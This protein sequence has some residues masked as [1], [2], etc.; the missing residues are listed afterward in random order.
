MRH[1]VLTRSAYGPAWDLAANRRRLEISRAVTARLLACQT[2]RN[3]TWIVLLDERDPLLSERLALY[4][5]SAPALVPILRQSGEDDP[6]RRAAADYRA[7]WRAATGPADDMVLMTRV[8]DDDGFAPDAL[9]RYQKAARPLRRR[10]ALMLELGARVWAG[11]YT[12]IRHPR[13]AMH[14]LVTPPG[15]ELCVYDYSHIVVHRRVKVISVDPRL[16]W[17]WVRHQDTISGHHEGRRPISPFIRQ[18]FP[19]DWPA[20][21]AAWRAS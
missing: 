21:E 16:G 20:L 7:P 1:Y 17:L 8:D 10:T 6:S 5:A 2:A 14:T 9:A 15:D 11:R 12:L 4:R 19:I 3:W 18:T 13:N